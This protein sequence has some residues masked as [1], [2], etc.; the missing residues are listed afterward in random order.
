MH[1]NKYAR[2]YLSS[3]LTREVKHELLSF[4]YR[5]QKTI[6]RDLTNY[7]EVRVNS[8]CSVLIQKIQN[9]ENY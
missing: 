3:L 2:Y 8:I 6:S 5:S 1:F 7:V 9:F 4:F